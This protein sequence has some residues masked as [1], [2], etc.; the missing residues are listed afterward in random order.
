MFAFAGSLKFINPN[1]QVVYIISNGDAYTIF[2]GD[3]IFEG[4]AFYYLY[5]RSPRPPY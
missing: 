3:D 4:T 2:V 5:S 1:K